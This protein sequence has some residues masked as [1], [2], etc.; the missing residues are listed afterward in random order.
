MR[1]CTLWNCQ[2]QNHIQKNDRDR[3]DDGLYR[4]QMELTTLSVLVFEYFVHLRLIEAIRR[5]T[6]LGHL[7]RRKTIQHLLDYRSA[8]MHSCPVLGAYIS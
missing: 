7:R 2:K 8:C 5:K 6:L 4:G 3:L 1:N